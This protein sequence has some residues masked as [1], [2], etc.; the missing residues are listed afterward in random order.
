MDQWN[1]GSDRRSFLAFAAS[2]IPAARLLAQ[3]TQAAKPTFSTDVKVVNVFAAVRDK[4]GKLVNDL[5]KDDFVLEEDGKPQTIRYFAQQSDLPLT[6]GLLVDTSGSVRSMI[7]TEQQASE[8]LFEQVL[9]PDRD[10]AFLIHFDREVELLQDVTS[11]R[12]RLEKALDLLGPSE[13]EREQQQADNRTNR[14]SGGGNPDGGWGGGGGGGIGFPGGGGR[15]GYG[16]H[17]GGGGGGNG[18]RFPHGGTKLYDAILLSSDEVMS[19]QSGRKATIL[20]TDGVDSGS[21][22]SLEDAIGSAQ[23]ADA[24]VYS[25]Y[26]EGETGR[27]FVRSGM[28]RRGGGNGET[29]PDG[30]KVLKQVSTQ[31]GGAYFETSKKKPVDEIYAQIENELRNQYSIGYTPDRPLSESGYRKIQLTVKGKGLTVQAREGYY[32]GQKT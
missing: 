11:S 23:R 21:K 7:G 12:T 30:K 26:V 9:R 22:T 24:L 17:S 20:L 15:G 31:T 19:K 14:P 13:S 2:V 25:I 29:R 4:D 8:K 10:K 3:D 18:R 27:G 28:S 1:K 5:T 32:A 16:R 6:L